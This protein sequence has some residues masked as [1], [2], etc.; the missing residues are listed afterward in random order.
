MRSEARLK[1]TLLFVIVLRG[2]DAI[3]PYAGYLA[4]QAFIEDIVMVIFCFSLPG[5]F[6]KVCESLIARIVETGSG[7]LTVISPASSEELASA[8]LMAEPSNIL[9][10]GHQPTASLRHILKGTSKPLL[11]SVDDP[12]R[13]VWDLISRNGLDPA[14]AIRQVASSCASLMPCIPLPG[15]LLLHAE[16]D[17]PEI[18]IMAKTIS[19]H[20]GAPLEPGDLN[21]IATQVGSH[22][23]NDAL[24]WEPDRLGE[25]VLTLANGALNA[26]LDYFLGSPFGQITW[27]RE[28]F[29][30]DDHQPATHPV[31]ITGR[32]R[33]LIYGPYFKLPPGKWR[34]EVVLGFSQEAADLNFLVDVKISDSVL[35][36][37]SIRPGRQGVF[38][39]NLSF[40]IDEDNEHAV[41]FRIMNERAAFEGRVMLGH[42]AL[43]LQQEVSNVPDDVLRAELGLAP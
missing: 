6:G 36:T 25:P 16:R 31:D 19:D 28:L 14:E 20:F 5:Q 34:A 7:P 21:D 39:L 22:L 33:A 23:G 40:A 41:E 10:R 43:S 8:M 42:V 30:T 37:T 17:W 3:G 27:A 11:V 24:E 1:A 2:A 13:G 15:A 29:F 4:D 38:T 26:Y 9:V 12:R 35:S 18:A 32:V